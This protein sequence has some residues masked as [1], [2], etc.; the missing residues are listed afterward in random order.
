VNS[1]Q[2]LCKDRGSWYK[3]CQEGLLQFLQAG[4]LPTIKVDLFIV[5]VEEYLKEL[6]IIQDIKGTTNQ[7]NPT[8]KLGLAGLCYH[9]FLLWTT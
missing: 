6:E 1:R 2:E 3:Q 5:G 7:H 8:Q 9:N 4:M